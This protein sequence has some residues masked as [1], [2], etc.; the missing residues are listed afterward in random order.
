MRYR[1]TT[2]YGTWCNQVAPY[3]TSPDDDVTGY[4]SGGDNDW[5]QLLDASG[6][7]EQIRSEYRD[8][9]NAA[10][11]DSVNLCGDEFIGP[12][13][14]DDGEWDGYPTEEDGGLDIKACVEGIDLEPILRRNDIVTLADIGRFNLGSKAKN[15]S[16]AA[17]Q[18]MRRL[19][20]KPIARVQ[21]DGEG[22]PIAVY[23]AAEVDKALAAR[24]GRGTRTDLKDS[25]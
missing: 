13:Q 1:T 15:P 23:N 17:S 16:S 22:Q 18:A 20:I 6:A 7:L 12:H 21:I 9:I 3:S 11:P 10:L 8:A 5:Q 19:G 2:S 4:I 25:K 14:P 24:P